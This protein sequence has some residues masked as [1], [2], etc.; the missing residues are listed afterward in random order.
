V[1]LH[2]HED[3]SVAVEQPS[4]QEAGVEVVVVVEHTSVGVITGG[5]VRPLGWWRG[6]VVE[7]SANG[8]FWSLQGGGEVVSAFHFFLVRHFTLGAGFPFFLMFLGL[9]RGGERKLW[10]T[11]KWWKSRDFFSIL[12]F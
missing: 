11:V 12:I 2:V 9:D 8:V 3:V 5:A 10:C 4:A 6:Q 7:A 1:S